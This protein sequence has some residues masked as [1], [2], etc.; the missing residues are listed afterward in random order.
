ME[1]GTGPEGS[2]FARFLADCDTPCGDLLRLL[3][4]V[5]TEHGEV[6]AH[7]SARLGGEVLWTVLS[8]TEAD[9]REEAARFAG[10][11]GGIPME[12]RETTGGDWLCTPSGWFEVHTHG[13]QW[14]IMPHIHLAPV[15]KG[16]APRR[17]SA[18]AHAAMAYRQL[19]DQGRVQELS[20]M[21][22]KMVAP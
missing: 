4:V 12:W 16:T 10:D 13:R 20:A 9:A 15:A 21:V 2:P 18:K 14:S 17:E 5:T 8:D 7:A 19:V 6:C 22:A 3:V 11:W 1:V